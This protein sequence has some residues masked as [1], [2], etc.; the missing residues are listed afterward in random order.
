MNKKL[1]ILKCLFVCIAF[2]VIVSN[3]SA[4]TINNQES[5]LTS[6]DASNKQTYS[7]IWSYISSWL[8]G[9]KTNNDD[10]DNGVTYQVIDIID[11]NGNENFIIIEEEPITLQ[12]LEDSRDD[13]KE[14]CDKIQAD[15]DQATKDGTEVFQSLINQLN[16]CLGFLKAADTDLADLT[17]NGTSNDEADSDN[18]DDDDSDSDSDNEDDD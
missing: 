3:V 17:N 16:E 13:I 10:D 18:D 5:T 4:Q 7:G 6:T 9:A 2:V 14:N 8:G 1:E 15:I 12:E 11:E